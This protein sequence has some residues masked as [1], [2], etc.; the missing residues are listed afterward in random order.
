MDLRRAQSEEHA[1]QHPASAGILQTKAQTHC[2]M[3][4]HRA[5]VCL[6]YS[7]ARTSHNVIHILSRRAEI[8]MQGHVTTFTI[9]VI[10]LHLLNTASVAERSSLMIQCNSLWRSTRRD[11]HSLPLGPASPPSSH[12]HLPTY[13]TS[14]LTLG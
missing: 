4:I 2:F 12:Q 7:Q 3:E 1:A 11:G 6:T 14:H 5:T 13:D 8:V 10:A 9:Q